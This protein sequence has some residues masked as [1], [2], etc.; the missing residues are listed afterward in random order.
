MYTPH[1]SKPV[2]RRIG[3]VLAR[4]LERSSAMHV[5]LHA[6]QSPPTAAPSTQG[7]DNRDAASASRNPRE[8]VVVAGSLLGGL[9]AAAA[10][11]AF[12][13]GD[14]D[15]HAIT[16]A[17]LLG[18]AF[19]WALLAGLSARF[20][21]RPQRW[22]AV[23]AVAM[24]LTGVA[25]IAL[26]P[27]A[28]TLTTLGWVW[29]L[30]LVALVIWMTVQARRQL[31]NRTRRLLLYPVFAVLGLTALGGAYEALGNVTEGPAAEA[32]GHRLVDVGGYQLD[33]WCTGSG[34]PTVVLEPG[35]GQSAS[36]MARW[37]GPSVADTTRICVYDQAGHGRSDA[38][39]GKTVDAA[40]DLNVLLQ[41]AGIPG[42]YVMAGHSRGGL[43]VLDYTHRYPEQVAGV[44]L[45]DSMHPRQSNAFARVDPLMAVVPTL[46]RTGLARLLLDA[47]DGEPVQQARQ[48]ARDVTDLPAAMNRASKLTSLGDRRLAVITAGE[49]SQKGWREQQDQL[50]ALSSNS[51]HRIVAGS[52][53]QSLID[54][55]THAAQSSQAIRDIV[56]AV[57][58]ST[59][60]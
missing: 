7:T 52:T 31:S 13:F 34:S 21:D 44:V 53:H 33:I 19:G 51:N 11:V 47:K 6:K 45:L 60:Q 57:R 1:L 32:A 2:R 56:T 46:A 50:A 41:R 18:F 28:A 24:A 3:A 55:E 37:I 36:A 59:G 10:L 48:L 23:P 39:P 25:L 35:L 43:F 58:G 54:D 8:A 38:A 30:P 40:R 17:I 16:G 15:E 9:A 20:T 14:A 26:A 5:R 29:P 4:L 49:G 42:P 27:G 22:A 12:P